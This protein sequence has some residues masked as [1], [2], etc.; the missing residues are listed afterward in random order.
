MIGAPE[1][2]GEHPLVQTMAGVAERG[3][4]RQ[5]LAGPET[6]QGDREVV[7]TDLGHGASDAL[8]VCDINWLTVT[9]SEAR[10]PVP[11]VPRGGTQSRRS[12]A[13]GPNSLLKCRRGLYV[14]VVDDEQ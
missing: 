4:E 3:V 5:A 9:Q 2:G 13:V 1:L 11:E 12:G 7:D 6:V 10:P 8:G 14:S